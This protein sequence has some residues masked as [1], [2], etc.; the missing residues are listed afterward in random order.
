MCLK[1]DIVCLKEDIICVFKGGHCLLV[2]TTACVSE[3][4][5]YI[6]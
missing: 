5:L 3:E 2:S 4:I 6:V 1:E